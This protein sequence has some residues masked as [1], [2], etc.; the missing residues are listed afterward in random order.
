VPDKYSDLFV[1]ISQS[2]K[3]FPTISNVSILESGLSSGIP[4][5]PYGCANGSCG[6]CRARVLNGSVDKIRFH[7]YAL[8]EAEKLA[9]VCLLCSY[10]ATTDIVVEVTTASSVLDIPVQQVRGKLCYLEQLNSIWIGRFK[11]TRGKALRYIPGQYATLT[12]PN[13]QQCT[14][15]VANCPCESSYLE[16]HIPFDAQLPIEQ[17]KPLDRVTIDGPSG[18]FTLNDLRQ[19]QSPTSLSAEKPILFVAVGIGFSAIKPLVEHVL[20]IEEETSCAL[21]WVASP[22]VGHYYHNLCRSWSDAFDQFEFIQINKADEMINALAHQWPGQLADSD[23]YISTQSS[24]CDE[25]LS[26]LITA[27]ADLD[28]IIVDSGEPG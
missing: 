19:P 3:Q 15:P 18:D 1:Q 2:G 14:L 26:L 20:S 27:G 21:L 17:L 5:L 22:T 24:E 10:A 25:Y 6:D 12:F 28:D 7:D 23:V 11:L 16:F 9:G 13:N 4:P 8:T